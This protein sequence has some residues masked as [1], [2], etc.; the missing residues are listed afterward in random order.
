M[1]DIFSSDIAINTISSTNLN[2]IKTILFM[3]LM[4]IIALNKMREIILFLSI[5]LFI[6]SISMIIIIKI[7][8]HFYL[9]LI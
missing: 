7:C 1:M 2:L 4:S 6:F 5:F 9:E 8:I 3:I